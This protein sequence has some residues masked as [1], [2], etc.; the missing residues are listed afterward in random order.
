MQL[1]FIALSFTAVFNK[2]AAEGD[3]HSIDKSIMF[4]TALME[5]LGSSFQLSWPLTLSGTG[6]EYSAVKDTNKGAKHRADD[7]S[8]ELELKSCVLTFSPLLCTG[9][10]MGALTTVVTEF[11]ILQK[12]LQRLIQLQLTGHGVNTGISYPMLG[13][14]FPWLLLWFDLF[15]RVRWLWRGSVGAPHD[16]HTCRRFII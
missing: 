5:V 14:S 11:R 4:S 9:F 16:L 2:V 1:C 10:G 7:P 3:T 8:H 15:S 13:C 12:Q 6:D